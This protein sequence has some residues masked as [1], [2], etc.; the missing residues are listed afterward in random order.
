[1]NPT[2]EDVRILYEQME[3]FYE[4]IVTRGNYYFDLWKDNIKREEFVE[5][6]RNLLY[7]L[8]VR[9]R[10]IRQ[11]QKSL[12]PWGLSSLGR[13]ESKTIPT[14][15]AVLAS[16]KEMNGM[17]AD[18][19][20]ISHFLLGEERLRKNT[21]CIFTEEEEDRYTRIMVTLDS[22]FMEKKNIAEKLI[23]KGMNIA[24]INCS[25]DNEEIWLDMINKVRAASEKRNK[26]VKIEV[27][28]SGPKVRT[29]FVYTENK[30]PRVSSGDM[31]HLCKDSKNFDAHKDAKIHIGIH[32]Q[33]VFDSL[34]IGDQVSIDDGTVAC[35]I[36]S[37]DDDGVMLLVKRVNGDTLRVK[38]EQGVN[39]PSTNFDMNLIT[40]KDRACIE[41]ACKH[42]DIIGFSFVKSRQD[43]K[44]IRKELAK[45]LG[46][47][48][49]DMPI[50][51]KIETVQAVENL[52]GIIL[53]AAST[54]PTC[55]MIARGDLAVESGYSRLGE[56]QQEILWVCEASD[57]PVI[58][59]TEVLANQI[60]RGIPT[61]AEISDAAESS[62]A[63]CVMLNKGP[64]MLEGLELL[65]DI[66]GKMKEHHFKKTP[67]LRPLN[68]AKLHLD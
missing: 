64:H 3:A 4:E 23:E 58:W 12:I 42:A 51:V 63:E 21:N 7:Y 46:D 56:L 32:A 49:K 6:A 22:S 35:D 13:L 52:P 1:M 31:I 34:D 37:K 2:K 50:M 20:P 17:K 27:E 30:N 65:T 16:L 29:S 10:D 15:E 19:P 25:H 18:H 40:E 39:F 54:N 5:S 67:M 11:L 9:R 8:T 26:P 53:E 47:K 24:R 61:R 33:E 41:F 43:I 45:H 59:A 14:L 68:I 62:R 57:T 55:V 38:S 60:K 28:I 48:A 66:L 36:I 44:E